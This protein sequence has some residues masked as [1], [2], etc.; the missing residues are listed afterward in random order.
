MYVYSWLYTIH[1]I[2]NIKYSIF[3]SECYRRLLQRGNIKNHKTFFLII[4]V[5]FSIINYFLVFFL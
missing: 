1:L 4:F 3:L 5:F 2:D